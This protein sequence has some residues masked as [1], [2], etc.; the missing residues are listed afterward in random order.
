MLKFN[1]NSNLFIPFNLIGTQ[2]D[3]RINNVPAGFLT[4]ATS[5]PVQRPSPSAITT[6]STANGQTM[7]HPSFTKSM[8]FNGVTTTATTNGSSKRTMDDIIRQ[9]TSLFRGSSINDVTQFWTLFDPLSTILSLIDNKAYLLRS[10]N[11]LSPPPMYVTSFKGDPLCNL[12]KKCYF[13]GLHNFYC[14]DHL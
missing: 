6:T 4:S 5:L 7:S 12:D 13:F 9:V 8:S 10:Q 1:S 11:Q 2:D 3:N 14:S